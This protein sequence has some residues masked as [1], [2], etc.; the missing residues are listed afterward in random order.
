MKSGAASAKRICVCTSNR[1]D[2]EPRA[3][4]HAL[5]IA[6]SD[7]GADVTLLDCA[8]A[9]GRDCRLQELK[10]VPRL[11]R[12]THYFGHRRNG[13]MK[14]IGCRAWQRLAQVL[15]R[16][17]KVV[18]SGVLSPYTVGVEN[19][20]ISVRADVYIAHD[21]S[22]LLPAA[23][24]AKKNGARLIF[25][26]MEFYS[27]M[28]DS[29]SEIESRI[30]EK[31]ESDW[32]PQCDLV[33]ASSDLV[34]DEYVGKY[35][36]SRPL[37]LYNCPRSEDR[38]PAKDSAEFRLYWRNSVIDLGQR[39]LDNAF[40]ALTQL[41]L[42]ISLHIQGRLPRDRRAVVGA[43]MHELGI[44]D[45]V[46]V[47]SPYSAEQAVMEASPHTIGLCLEYPGIRNQE[48]TV[49]NKIFDYMM[50][51]LP[52]VSSDLPGLAGVVDRSH[53]GVLYRSGD[54][55]DLAAKISMLYHD[56]EM[57]CRL[58]QNARKFALTEG[59]RAAQMRVFVDAVRS[60]VCS[61]EY[62]KR[63]DE[64]ATLV[65]ECGTPS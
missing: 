46:V 24:A 30:I 6:C 59:N 53:G 52:V 14:L 5:A 36:I 62:R 3:P 28:G 27:D 11:S 23:R 10:D 40:V 13:V 20:L 43:R 44:A 61:E 32:L 65:S 37:A 7:L 21:I 57:R 41:P 18:L 25:D 45:R 16:M 38:L 29:Q 1:A 51:G 2:A 26:C 22:M 35:G 63:E 42:D 34:A 49:S 15:F 4:R 9:G 60:I 31:L 64:E 50:A 12:I 48:I 47:H 58:G 56:H 55:S 33:L 19:K 39:G 17:C 54:A 8:P